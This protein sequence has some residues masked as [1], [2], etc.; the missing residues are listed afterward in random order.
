ML[1]SNNH[2]K[3]QSPLCWLLTF[4]WT[5]LDSGLTTLLHTKTKQKTTSFLM[6]VL[7]IYLIVQMSFMTLR[8]MY[9][10][11]FQV[12]AGCFTAVDSFFFCPTLFQFPHFFKNTPCR[13]IPSFQLNALWESPCWCKNIILCWLSMQRNKWEQQ[14]ISADSL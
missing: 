9:W 11:S 2:F 14:L 1:V 13:E 4:L 10:G 12:F 3:S 6:L 5:R 7:L 8:W